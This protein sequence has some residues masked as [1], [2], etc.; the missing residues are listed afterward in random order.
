MKLLNAS[1]WTRRVLAVFAGVAASLA[2]AQGAVTVKHTKGE[3]TLQER[4]AS[5]VVMDLAVLDTLHTLG[6]EVQ[7]V[8]AM[9]YR[10]Q[11]SEFNDK[12]YLRI[13][14]VFEPDYETI[15]AA[16]PELIIVAG[17][18]SP[19]YSALAKLAPTLDLTVDPTDLLGS[20]KRN[21]AA[22]ATIFGRE[23]EAQARLENLDESIA[24]LKKQSPEAG[25]ALIVLTT[26]GKMSAY[27]PGSRF[28]VIHDELGIMPATRELQTTNHGQAIS[29]EF[30]LKTDPDWL[31]VIDRDAAIGRE[32]QSAGQLLDNELIHQTKA[33]KNQRVLYL[34]ALNWYTIGSAGLTAMQENVDQLSSALKRGTAVNP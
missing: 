23:A 31:F 33:W 20:M 3:L 19:K 16:S 25:T 12:K 32:G 8:P 24:A 4:P 17:R 30:I 10:R 34:D 15:H 11:L 26:G 22:L 5:V 13:G 29:F 28:G 9:E 2:F 6:V 1:R 7:G 27:G 18:S 14:S 21:T